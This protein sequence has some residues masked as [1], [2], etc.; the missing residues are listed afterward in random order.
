M[1][2]SWVCV[3]VGHPRDL[4]WKGQRA[5]EAPQG[6]LHRQCSSEGAGAAAASAGAGGG[7]GGALPLSSTR[8]VLF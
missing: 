4:E 2:D 8:H 3:D 5:R 7:G 6:Y 1:W